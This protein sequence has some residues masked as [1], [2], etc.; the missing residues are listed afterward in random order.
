MKEFPY[1]EDLQALADAD[2]PSGSEELDLERRVLQTLATP[3]PEPFQW[4]WAL[5]IGAGV[6]AAAIVGFLAVQRPSVQAHTLS[7]GTVQLADQVLATVD[8]Q[9][10]ALSE[11][12]HADVQWTEGTLTVDVEP[13]V[14]GRRVTVE[15]P[16]VRVVVTGTV[17]TVDRHPFGTTVRVDRGNVEATCTGVPWG[18]ES[19]AAGT[20][21]VCL[22]HAGMGLGQVILL[23]RQ[24]ASAERR[25][26]AIDRAL[27]YPDIQESREVL[28]GKRVDALVELRQPEQA[29]AAA[30]TLPEPPRRAA[31]LRGAS[32]ALAAGG[33]GAARG[34]LEALVDDGDPTGTLHQVQCLAADDPAGARRLLERLAPQELTPS[35]A[36]AVEQ[37][38][39]TLDH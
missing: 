33:C 22:R 14:E 19:V 3:P 26:A 30:L 17:F 6:A 4:R 18:A 36:R 31:L 2:A 39:A 11:G 37:W 15:T 9:G 12:I 38:R 13:G 34:W 24:G 25:L 20:E 29:I 10:T 27:R 7:T 35:Q 1:R 8:G 21:V 16:E 23:E 5:A 28:V 32:D